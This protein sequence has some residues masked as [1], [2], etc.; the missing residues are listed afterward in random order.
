[1]LR[2]SPPAEYCSG[3]TLYKHLFAKS[4]TPEHIILKKKYLISYLIFP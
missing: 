3:D 2:L 4:F 1:M